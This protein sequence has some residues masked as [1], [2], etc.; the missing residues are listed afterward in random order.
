MAGASSRGC[1]SKCTP[2]AVRVQDLGQLIILR[3]DILLKPLE[4]D[5]FTDD[6]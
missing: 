5:N 6:G 4:P 1:A 3:Q 2:F